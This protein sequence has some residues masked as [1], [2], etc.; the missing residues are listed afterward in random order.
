LSEEEELRRLLQ[1]VSDKGLRALSVQELDLLRTLLSAKD[2]GDNKKA[3]KSRKK[4]IRK[5]NVE[6]YNKYSP[7]RFF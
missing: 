1:V 6:I 7:R 3:E 4:L 5:I 2:Y